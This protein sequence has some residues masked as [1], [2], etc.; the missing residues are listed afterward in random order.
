MGRAVTRDE[1]QAALVDYIAHQSWRCDYRT[2]YGE[3]CCG[4]DEITAALGI[5]PVPPDDPESPE[6]L[7]RRASFAPPSTL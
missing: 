5:D 3:C 7:A 6:A 2:R 1:A 4:L